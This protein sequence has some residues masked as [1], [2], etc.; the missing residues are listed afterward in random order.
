MYSTA[1]HKF[2]GDIDRTVNQ[3]V[4]KFNDDYARREYPKKIGTVY[5]KCKLEFQSDSTDFISKSQFKEMIEGAVPAL[6]KKQHS[7]L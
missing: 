4:E 3:W 6:M 5:P 2:L 7:Y 1:D